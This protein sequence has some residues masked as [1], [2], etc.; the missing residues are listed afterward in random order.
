MPPTG[1]ISG[2]DTQKPADLLHLALPISQKVILVIDLV[3]SVRLMSADEAGTVA[4]WHDF[5]RHAQTHAIPAH[6]GRLVKSLGDGLMLEFLQAR[7]AVNAA[8][9]LHQALSRS[10]AGLSA[11]LQMHL[12][13][14]INASQIYSDQ[15]D[16]YGAG[17]NLAA[18]LATLAGPGE[19]VVSASVRDGLTDG[20]D[21]S[22]EDLGECYL[23]H[24]EAPVRAYR[25]G[26]EGTAPVVAARLDYEVA[27]QPTIAVIPFESRSTAPAF[28]AVGE[29][30]ADGVIA[31]LSRSRDFTVISRLS[32]TAF[33]GRGASLGDI[34]RC[35]GANYVLSGTY[36]VIGNQGGGKLLVT[37]ELAESKTNQIVWLER[38]H[39]EVGDLLQSESECVH[40]IA[41]A[42]HISILNRETELVRQQPMATLS[43]YALKLSGIGL[44]HRSQ[45][46]DFETAR[47]VLSELTER[48]RRVADTHAWLAKW[49]VLRVIRG[50]SA[51]P[52]DDAH[53]AL[54]ACQRALDVQPEH[55]LA[56]AVKGY[57]LCQMLGQPEQ[58]RDCLDRAIALSPNEVHARLYRSVW[59]SLYGSTSEGVEEAV[60]AKQLSPFD[61]HAYFLETI[62]A[63][64]Y[65]F[66][67]EYDNAIHAA[68]RSLKLDKNHAPTLRALLLA[69]VEGEHLED[70][71]DTLKRLLATTP[72]LTIGAYKAMGSDESP[73]R[74][75][76]IAALRTL[77]VPE[78]S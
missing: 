61:P 72:G 23:K 37:V 24:L 51:T 73:G 9:A 45:V 15:L 29:L 59:S 70:A 56:L 38:F 76:V 33:R 14:G 50:I 2:T 25:V 17:V 66:N 78:N 69:Q 12:R 36:W 22:I 28:D 21:A 7:D 43:A 41:Q 68:R 35:L 48:H 77:G 57:A 46:A 10:N 13:A 74:Q 34:Q 26:V 75:R 5:V 65:A 31:Q 3:E 54:D 44:M 30:I 11:A 39:T 16:I 71:Q 32:A 55:P 67:H 4:R 1:T 49:H 64:A 40:R 20:L 52:A 8:Q 42:T 19:T 47:L 60:M 62:L 27:L 58:A 6:Q 63:S 53:H 18:R